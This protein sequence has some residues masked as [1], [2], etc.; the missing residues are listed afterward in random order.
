MSSHEMEVGSSPRATNIEPFPLEEETVGAKPEETEALVTFLPRFKLHILGRDFWLPGTGR[1]VRMRQEVLKILLQRANDENANRMTREQLREELVARGHRVNRPD[2][3][4]PTSVLDIGVHAKGKKLIARD[5]ET[6]TFYVN[7]EFFEVLESQKD[8]ST[9]IGPVPPWR[10]R[11]ETD[12]DNIYEDKSH[13]EAQPPQ[14]KPTLLESAAEKELDLQARR[15]ETGTQPTIPT[16]SVIHLL[17]AGE[18]YILRRRYGLEGEE[19]KTL[20]EIGKEF[21]VTRERIRQIE[22]KAI[23]RLSNS[24]Q[25]DELR[26]LIW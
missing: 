3:S 21:D 5:K 10:A 24:S 19:K 23:E 12:T 17:S 1:H 7:P 18:R 11:F 6:N 26:D 20:E 2:L 25:A 16:I 13:E 4:G 22:A 8:S 9:R 14:K 15:R